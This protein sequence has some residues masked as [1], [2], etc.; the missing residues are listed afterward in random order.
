MS[1]CRDKNIYPYHN[2]MTSGPDAVCIFKLFNSLR[3]PFGST[4]ISLMGVKGFSTFRGILV[5]DLRVKA[6]CTNI[7]LIK[8]ACFQNSIFPKCIDPKRVVYEVFY[9]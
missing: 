9:K 1:A 6:D 5:S 2:L 7:C 8:S 4:V 3:T